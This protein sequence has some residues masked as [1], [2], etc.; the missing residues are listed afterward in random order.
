MR[1]D[2]PPTHTRD[3]L[4]TPANVSRRIGS[5]VRSGS[6]IVDASSGMRTSASQMAAGRRHIT[7]T[8]RSGR[9]SV[10]IRAVGT[11]VTPS[12]AHSQHVPRHPVGVIRS[13]SP[14]ADDSDQPVQASAGGALI[15]VGRCA[16]VTASQSGARR[17]KCAPRERSAVANPRYH[18]HQR[19]LGS[20]TQRERN[21]RRTTPLPHSSPNDA[22]TPGPNHHLRGGMA[23]PKL[24]SYVGRRTLSRCGSPP[25]ASRI[26]RPCAVTAQITRRSMTITVIAQ[27]G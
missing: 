22:G 2:T 8:G 10:L 14:T 23:R 6:L 20:S 19:H 24:R 26:S 3:L 1:P 11:I 16:S 27:S 17:S 18:V 25:Y 7:P 15:R 21:R 13:A 5:L 9:T 12:P 4:A